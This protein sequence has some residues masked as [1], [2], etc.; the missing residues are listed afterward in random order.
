MF[1]R[2]EVYLIP[3]S[4][5]K[6]DSY[7]VLTVNLALRALIHIEISG[8]LRIFTDIHS[9]KEIK[10]STVTLKMTSNATHST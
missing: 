4:L 1:K 6:T 8:L 2:G 7:T 9:I 5:I 3:S 10:G